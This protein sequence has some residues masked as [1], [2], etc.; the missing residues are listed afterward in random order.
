MNNPIFLGLL[1]IVLG[2]ILFFV[3]KW[4]QNT[5]DPANRTSALEQIAQELGG[6]FLPETKPLLQNI[7]GFMYE[8][9]DS[10]AINTL[11]FQLDNNEIFITD[12][13]YV[14]YDGQNEVTFHTTVVAIPIEHLD[15]P[16]FRV[17]P[18]ILINR[19]NYWFNIREQYRVIL[20]GQWRFNSLFSL[21]TVV[22]YTNQVR[23]FFTARR[24]LVDFCVQH[25][26]YHLAS[27]GEWL[28]WYVPNEQIRLHQRPMG[29]LLDSAKTLLNTIQ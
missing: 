2:T 5:Q 8:Q 19:V 25:R 3:F 23:K 21:K 26:D 4:R 22:T 20:Q 9:G 11:S 1:A 12:Y 6:W 17:R 24:P 15:I 10:Q 13:T 27:N 18:S 14:R 16:P 7:K 28:V 29:R